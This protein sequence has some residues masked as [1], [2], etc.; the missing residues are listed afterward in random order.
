[1]ASRSEQGGETVKFATISVNPYVCAAEKSRAFLI[2]RTRDGF[3]SQLA[4]GVLELAAIYELTPMVVDVSLPSEVG[5]LWSQAQ[6]TFKSLDIEAGD[7]LFI[8]DPVHIAALYSIAALAKAAEAT[9]KEDVRLYFVNARGT[10]F[11]ITELHVY[12][13]NDGVWSKLKW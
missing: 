7:T 12:V 4:E 2:V 11:K 9:G 13:W 6:R 1:M 3:D 8:A 5:E 10:Q